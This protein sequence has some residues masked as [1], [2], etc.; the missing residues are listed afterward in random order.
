MRGRRPRPRS[1]CKKEGCDNTLWREGLC[2][3][4]TPAEPADEDRSYEWVKVFR[5]WQRGEDNERKA[6]KDKDPPIPLT[7]R[8]RAEMVRRADMHKLTYDG[9]TRQT[10]LDSIYL[11]RWR[12]Y[13]D[14]H[15]MRLDPSDIYTA[16]LWSGY[17]DLDEE[18]EL[19]GS[20][21]TTPA[22]AGVVF[23]LAPRS[24]QAGRR[25][26]GCAHGIGGP[27]RKLRRQA[28]AA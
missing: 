7:W 4:C 21:A 16:R 9:W 18:S 14:K 5:A 11:R 15:G 17:V 24:H 20:H 6:D 19:V 28:H 23:T 8:E 3:G 26:A 12:T 27:R 13:L 25:P 1:I 2:R 10:G 22:L